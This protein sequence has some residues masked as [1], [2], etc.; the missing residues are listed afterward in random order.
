M[1]A[2]FALGQI[3]GPLSVSYMITADGDFSVALLLASSILAAGAYGLLRDPRKEAAARL[4]E[5]KLTERNT[6]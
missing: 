4:I 3:A 6:R 5:T 1:T 2:A